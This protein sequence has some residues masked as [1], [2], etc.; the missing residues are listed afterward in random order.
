MDKSIDLV[1]K[2]IEF[3]GPERVPVNYMHFVAKDFKTDFT[4]KYGDDFFITPPAGFEREPISEKQ[5][6]DEWGCIWE[7]F[8]DTMGEV[9]GHP[10]KDWHTLSSLKIPDNNPIRYE[11][12]RPLLSQNYNKFKIAVIFFFLF[13][14][15]HSLR[16]FNQLMEDLYINRENVEKLCDM[17]VDYNIK[18]I[19]TFANLGYDGIFVT[20]D[21]GV[22]DRLMINP[23]LWRLIFKS[24]YKSI[25]DVVHQKGMKF[26]LHS[27]GHISSIIDDLIEIGVDV[28]QLDQ[29][30]NMGIDFL[31]KNFGGKICFFCP[32][33]I[34]TTLGKNDHKAIEAKAKEL[35]EKFGKFN[36]GFIAKTYPQPTDI[37]ATE[38][39]VMVMCEAFKK[40]GQYKTG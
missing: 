24:K 2:A 15:M 6:R 22:Q 5:S 37:G 14:R 23:Q 7:S 4:A 28:L 19:N 16:G 1:K 3:R 27:C 35:I 40:Y 12:V 13:E 21:W 18:L 34:Q 20:D 31:S 38:E 32:T 8:N 26:F 30:D 10:L 29:Q 9:K 11:W 17:L 25:I 39:S 36:G 33:D